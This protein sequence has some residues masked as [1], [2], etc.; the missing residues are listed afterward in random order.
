L[1]YGLLLLLEDEVTGVEPDDGGCVDGEEDRICS[2][3]L[4]LYQLLDDKRWWLIGF[5]LQETDK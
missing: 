2:E 4:L 3:L 5:D 1:L